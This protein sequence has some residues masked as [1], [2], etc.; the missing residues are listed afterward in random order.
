MAG[1]SI[2]S[3]VV[4]ESSSVIEEFICSAILLSLALNPV[5]DEPYS[6][7]IVYFSPLCTAIG[8]L[9]YTVGALPGA[10]TLMTYASLN[11][12]PPLS[13]K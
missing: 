13:L 3:L 12:A 5:P 4:H 11:N 7:D 2:C 10:F 1:N 6:K 8:Y 9:L